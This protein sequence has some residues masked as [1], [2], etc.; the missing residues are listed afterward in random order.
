MRRV[1]RGGG[2]ID[3]EHLTKVAE[4]LGEARAHYAGPNEGSYEFKIYKAAAIKAELDKLFHGKCAYCERFF[5]SGA[6]V[7]VEH[8]R[9]KGGVEGDTTHR[10]YWW[11]AMEWSN[12][13]PSCIDCNRRRGQRTPRPE[14][15]LE[16]LYDGARVRFSESRMVTTGGVP[17]GRTGDRSFGVLAR[18]AAGGDAETG[19][20][21]PAALDDGQGVGRRLYRAFART[22]LDDYQ[23]HA[24]K[25]L[26]STTITN[27]ATMY[28]LIND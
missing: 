21:A 4:E 8:Y 14:T 16:R 15:S 13:L 7:D 26:P 10:G 24:T 2:P 17:R 27:N 6:P 11:L 3:P 12:L 20:T 28:K 9:P 25:G 19:R 18:H 5:A 1:D 23:G 22:C